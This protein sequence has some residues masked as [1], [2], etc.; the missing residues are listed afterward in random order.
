MIGPAQAASTTSAATVPATS[1]ADAAA[2]DATGLGD[3]IVTAQRRPET[4]QR[5]AVAVD[6]V[7]A[8]GLLAN[9]ITDPTGLGQVVPALTPTPAGFFL[10][11][12][13]NFTV[14]PTADP[15]IA[16]NYD[17]VYIGRPSAVFGLFF[18]LERVEVLEGPQGTLYGRNAT[19]GAI[20]VI[21][22]KPQIGQTSAY[23]TVS[24]GNN[25]YLTAEGAINLP[26]GTSGALRVSGNLLQHDAY[27]SDG[28]SNQKQG[29]ARVQLLAELT[30]A[31]T[32]RLAADYEHV[33]GLGPGASYVTAYRYNPVLGQY[34]ARPANLGTDIG[35]YDT[36]SQAFL[37]SVRAGPAGRNFGVLSPRP[38]Q[39]SNYYG[40]NAEIDYDTGIGKLT[41]IPAYRFND[42]DSRSGVP[43]FTIDLREKDEQYSFEARFAGKRVSIFDYTLGALYYHEAN[44][45][46][47]SIDQQALAV[48]QD[49]RQT[50]RSFAAFARLTANLTDTLRAVG[51]VRYTDDTK[52]FNGNSDRLTVVCTAVVAGV[53]TCPN[54]PLFPLVATLAAQP[55]PVPARSGGVAPIIG[56]GAIVSRGSVMVDASL[57]TQRVTYRG[58]VEFDVAPRSL[59]YGSVETGF[60][61]GG[62]S[63]STGYETYQPEYITAYTL[64]SKNRF[65]HDRLQ[66]NLEAFLWQYRNQQVSHL[67][68]DLAGQ[69][70][71]FTQ[72]IGRSLNKGMSA[73]G[74]VRLTPTAILSTE[75]QYL[76]ARYQS[77]RYQAPLGNAPVLT[78][79]AQAIDTVNPALRDVDCAGR[80]AFNAPRWTIN[81][82]AEQTIP[83]GRYKLVGSVDSQYR[84]SRYIGFDYLPEE[85]VG[86]TWQT[87]LQVTL[88][89]AHDRW[90]V[91]GFVRNLEDSRFAI[92]ANNFGLGNLITI[93][94]N[95]PRTYGVRVSTRF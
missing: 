51:G 71:N 53:P 91:G 22:A 87:N 52:D 92:T 15:A 84:T 56:T 61:S 14:T 47:Y 16:F 2:G 30:P 80:P 58:A 38:F 77:L 9:A 6:V 39:D 11:G 26:V 27:L 25:N 60:R 75:I 55:L 33:G 76:S 74:R 65:F 73:E 31:L 3:I 1:G 93:S 20:N 88:S 44:S 34:V 46:H 85:L 78:G 12:V 42:Q 18:D 57:P 95:D 69:T 43:A 94:T 41:I 81:L 79:C 66:L 10:R 36:Q 19:G 29:S 35:L 17:S 59:V 62:F 8:A 40:T 83:L 5:A 23:A 68:I 64:G 90:S 21:P 28:T 48:Y 24:Y 7:N 70:G 49:Y 89:D 50:T 37:T 67:G 54:A 13:G 82:G 63:L 72:N 4:L 45:I 32:V 86:A